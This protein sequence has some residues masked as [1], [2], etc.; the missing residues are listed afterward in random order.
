M[1]TRTASPTKAM[2]SMT[3]GSI[4]RLFARAQH[5]LAE[6]AAACRGRRTIRRS[7]GKT[8]ATRRGRRDAPSRRPRRRG[9][10]VAAADLRGAPPGR[11][12]DAPPA[13][14]RGIRPPASDERRGP[15]S[16]LRVR[17]PCLRDC[18]PHGASAIGPRLHFRPSDPPLGGGGGA[19]EIGSSPD[20]SRRLSMRHWEQR[21]EGGAV[22]GTIVCGVTD[23]DEGHA[24]L[25]LGVELSGGSAC[26]WCWRMS[27]RVRAARR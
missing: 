20:G 22:R 4:R 8:A 27:P 21:N 1:G 24:A 10:A 15:V 14:R 25:E 2:V 26:G 12:R 16:R 18:R 13:R 7:N 6:T 9:Q 23:S 19:R 11:T 5:A 17:S 3:S